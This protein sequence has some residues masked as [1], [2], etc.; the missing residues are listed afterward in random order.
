MTANQWQIGD[1]KITRIVEGET[2]GPMFLLPDATKENILAMPWLQPHFADAE[3]N[4]RISIHALVLEAPDRT[5][6][7]DTC[8]GNDKERAIGSWAH[9][10]TKFLEDLAGAGYSIESI[11]TVLCTHLHTDHVGWN[12][13]LENGQWVPTFPNAEYLFG[14]VEWEY[15][16]A[17]RENPMYEEFVV[18]SIQPIIDAGLVR[19]VDV[20]EKICDGISLVPTP[21]HTP[22]HVSVDIQSNGER[23][24]ITG[25]FLHHPCQMEEPYWECSADWDT[26]LAQKTRVEQL[27]RYADEGLLVFGTHFASPSA[28]RV[29]KKGKYFQF[30][31]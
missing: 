8:L 12:T 6:I 30:E 7:V 25:D 29:V 21:G 27:E 28:G 22:G 2:V 1:V 10:Q 11:D 5:I 13:R 17:Q 15:T 23:A 4:C 26:P 31:V 19:F 24:I 20:D 3:G 9:L 14:K 16:E 18:D